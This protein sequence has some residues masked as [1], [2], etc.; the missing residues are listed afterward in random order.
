M[1]WEEGDEKTERRPLYLRWSPWILR[2]LLS[3]LYPHFIF[4][5]P[6][7]SRATL[8]LSLLAFAVLLGS[9]LLGWVSSPLS[10]SL[11]PFRIARGKKKKKTCQPLAAANGRGCKGEVDEGREGVIFRGLRAMIFRSVLDIPR[12]INTSRFSATFE[13]WHDNVRVY[14]FERKGWFHDFMIKFW[15]LLCRAMR[16]GSFFFRPLVLQIY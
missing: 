14:C 6:T 7:G 9:S 10:S 15:G 12:K 5:H 1:G 4:Y 11:S 3:Y 16:A 13:R 8:I 2:V